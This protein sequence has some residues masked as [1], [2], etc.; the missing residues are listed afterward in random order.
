MSETGIHP[1]QE[2][3]HRAWFHAAVLK[4]LPVQVTTDLEK[5][6]DFSVEDMAH[7][8]T[9][10]QDEVNK[11]KKELEDTQ[12]QLLKLQLSEAREKYNVKKKKTKESNGGGGEGHWAQECPEPLQSPQQRGYWPQARGPQWGRVPCRGGHQAPNPSAAP[13]A[14]YP[15]ADWTWEE[16]Y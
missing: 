15:V 1:G 8:L 14:Q 3:E 4:G 12:A 11:Q 5:N 16:Q 13:V 10:E 6:P 7:R 9:L 2:G